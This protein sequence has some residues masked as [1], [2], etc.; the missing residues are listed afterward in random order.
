VAIDSL[1]YLAGWVAFPLTMLVVARFL[2]RGGH[3]SSYIIAMN[4]AAVPQWLV[5]MAVFALVQ[6]AGGA[7]SGVIHVAALAVM[8]FYDYYIAR[9]ALEISTGQA[10]AVTV[11][12]LLVALILDAVVF[13]LV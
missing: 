2:D 11:I 4:W 9:I 8:L 1:R 13:G 5:V 10:I 7:A 3:F 12:G 6:L